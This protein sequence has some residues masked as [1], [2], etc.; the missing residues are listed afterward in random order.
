MKKILITGANSYIGTSFENYIKK[1]DGYSVNTVDMVDGTWRNMDFSGY[2]AVFH[3][4]GIA[5]IK[6]T[7]ENAHL[8]YEVNRDL[9]FETAKKA[10]DAGISQF[11]F[12]SSMSVYGKAEGIITLSTTPNPK[13]NYGKSKLQAERKLESI[14]D[15]SDF[16]ISILRPPII[17]GKGCKGNY[18]RLAKFVAKTPIFPDFSNKRSM[19]YIENL[20]EFVRLIIDNDET[21]YFYPQNDEY[22]NTSNLV[23]QI[24]SVYNKNI[25]FV[26]CFNPIIQKL[27]CSNVVAKKVFG[28]L[29]YDKTMS[30]YKSDY[31]VC[32]F[33]ES[34]LR[35][36]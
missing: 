30:A 4:A 19:L 23:R 7:K 22:V 28:N 20:C 16:K 1:F 27:I 33:E 2:D 8:Y 6:E 9:A 10:K 12:L 34:I 29:Y 15:N 32:N 13:T 31:N 14:F 11:V 5:H 24:A 17:Y 25:K 18:P 21:G 36:I 3:V 26:K 35:V